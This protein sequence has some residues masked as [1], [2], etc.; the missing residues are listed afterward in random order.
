MATRALTARSVLLSVLLGTDPPRLPVALLV[1]TTALFGIAEGT[2][3]TA[4]SRMVASGD[5]RTDDGAYELADP[6]L[7]A[8]RTRQEASRRGAVDRWDGTW[9]QAV[10]VADGARPAPARAAL[11]ADLRAARLAELRDGV[12][13]RPANLGAPP[14]LDDVVWFRATAPASRELASDLW[15][16]HAWAHDARA[17]DRRLTAASPRLERGDRSMLADGFVLSA[18]VLRHLQADPLLPSQLLPV[19][20]PG[21]A[22]R[23]TYD[24]YDRAYRSVLA[25]WFRAARRDDR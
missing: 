18:D 25:D 19:G 15:D 11:R 6:A 4:L 7:L 23:D 2:T 20:W 9:T 5:V 10:V 16:L 14:P 13:M 21:V 22:L 3:R 1:R 17:L 24:R 12:W 8:R